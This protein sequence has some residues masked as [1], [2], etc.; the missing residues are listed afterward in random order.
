M[1]TQKSAALLHTD[2]RAEK[3]SSHIH[4]HN[5]YK[6]LYTETNFTKKVKELY[7]ENL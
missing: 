1:N 4:I 7:N 6:N 5:S 3:E 2:E